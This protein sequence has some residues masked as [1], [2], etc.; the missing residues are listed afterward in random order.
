MLIYILSPI[1]LIPELL[2][3]VVGFIDDIFFV[4]IA[5]LF[6]IA[7]SGIQYMRRA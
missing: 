5:I 4:I 6:S 1:D 2:V 7:N 3:G